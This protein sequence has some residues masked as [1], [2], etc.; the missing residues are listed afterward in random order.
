MQLV[1]GCPAAQ[2]AHSREDEARA[3]ARPLLLPLIL[4]MTPA[5][6]FSTTKAS[7]LGTPGRG[8]VAPFVHTCQ[9]SRGLEQ[10]CHRKAGVH[11]TN[12][13]PERTRPSA[14]SDL[15]WGGPPCLTF[16][17][18]G[19]GGAVPGP[20]QRGNEFKGREGEDKGLAVSHL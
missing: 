16:P 3:G 19:V 8:F 7:V 15:Q 17:T 1:G 20:A 12:T 18:R 6:M 13:C 11:S 10:V 14:L 2:E 4:S 5:S 9:R